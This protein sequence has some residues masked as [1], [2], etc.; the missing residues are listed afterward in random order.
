MRRIMQNRVFRN[1]I[2][3]LLFGAI[4]L[5][6]SSIFEETVQFGIVLRSTIIYF[7]IINLFYFIELVNRRMAAKNKEVN[8]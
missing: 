8:K 5:L 1:L 6:L 4:Y 7:V 3:T 2:S